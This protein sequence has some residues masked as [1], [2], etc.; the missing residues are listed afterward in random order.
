M[1]LKNVRHIPDLDI[2]LLLV[3]QL[4]DEEYSIHF[5]GGRGRS[6]KELP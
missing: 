3:G 2:N 4:D 6:P 5:G 1:V